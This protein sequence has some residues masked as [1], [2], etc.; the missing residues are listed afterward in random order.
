MDAVV[1]TQAPFQCLGSQKV[2]GCWRLRD[3]IEGCCSRKDA[4]AEGMQECGG[5]WMAGHS[6]G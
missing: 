5:H 6:E 4:E 1:H 2:R 3:A